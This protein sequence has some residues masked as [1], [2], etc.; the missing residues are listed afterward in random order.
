MT[1]TVLLLG[2]G[3]TDY[4]IPGKY[5]E[6]W[7]EGP[8][9]PLVRK[10][11]NKKLSFE[12]ILKNDLKEIKLQGKRP[13]IKEKPAIAALKLCLYAKKHKYNKVILF[14]DADREQGTK[15]TPGEAKKRF[16]KV[17]QT[18]SENAAPVTKNG[19]IIFV[20]M[21]ALKMIESWLMADE[22]AY[23]KCYGKEPVTP[24]L[25]SKPEF[26]W[27]KKKD[28]DSNYPK[29]YLK[30]VLN[31]F[32]ENPCRE[33]YHEIAEQ[34]DIETLKSKCAVSYKRFFDD[35]QKI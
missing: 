33:T 5:S 31:Q 29:N 11:V 27:G 23:K 1:E 25:P 17:Y 26:I 2:E 13:H 12:C 4:G 19:E 28:G 15:N 10:S 35:V 32:N 8:V 18:I 34:M 20:P 16:E 30:R 9:Q 3:P 6:A 14:S 22:K 7:K 21:V 24:T